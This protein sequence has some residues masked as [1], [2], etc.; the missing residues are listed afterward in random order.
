VADI[1][2]KINQGMILDWC[3]NGKMELMNGVFMI[4]TKLLIK[5]LIILLG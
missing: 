4:M 2:G 3:I 1:L 5:R